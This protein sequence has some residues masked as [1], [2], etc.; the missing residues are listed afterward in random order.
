MPREEFTF[1][2]RGTDGRIPAS[3]FVHAINNALTM[4]NNVDM[5]ASAST[6]PMLIWHIKRVSQRSPLAVT[7]E[8]EPKIEA[9]MPPIAVARHLVRICGH[10]ERRSVRPRDVLD[11]GLIAAKELVATLDRGLTEIIISSEG[12]SARLTQR[13]AANVDAILG[14]RFYYVDTELEGR[15]EGIVVHGREPEFYIYDLLT[16]DRTR[17]IFSP[18]FIPQVAD[19]IKTRARVRVSGRARYTQ[20]HKPTIVQVDYF[21]ALPAEQDLPTLEDLH[22][23]DINITGG[24]DPVEYVRRLRDVE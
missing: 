7:L 22:K 5:A 21:E 9:K 19:L 2:V 6:S 15:L 1:K 18:E 14:T 16:D 23:M 12:V 17:C 20:K 10:L 3:T 11:D 4:L 8:A 24:L 13:L